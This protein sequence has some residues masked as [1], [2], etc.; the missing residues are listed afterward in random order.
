MDLDALDTIGVRMENM[1]LSR[2]RSEISSVCRSL[3]ALEYI[4]ENSESIESIESSRTYLW[5]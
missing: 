2:V 5:T 4:G 3:D 1:R